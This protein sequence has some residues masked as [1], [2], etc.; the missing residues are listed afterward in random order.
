ME[1]TN[2]NFGNLFGTIDLLN[3]EHLEA[4]LSTMNQEHAVY[5]LIESVKAAYKRGAYTIGETEVISKAIRS[6]SVE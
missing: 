4:I 2:T 5:Y 1:N 3:E 6:I